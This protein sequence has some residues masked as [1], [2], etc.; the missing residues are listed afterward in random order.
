[1]C[2]VVLIVPNT[3]SVGRYPVSVLIL[4]PTCM[5]VLCA[6]LRVES[7]HVCVKHYYSLVIIIK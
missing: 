5:Y 1:M 7:M 2:T 3:T 6:C 4:D